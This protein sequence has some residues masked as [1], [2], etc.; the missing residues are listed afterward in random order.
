MKV[1]QEDNT[2]LARIA[3]THDNNPNYR[4]EVGRIMGIREVVV[5]DNYSGRF[6]PTTLAARGLV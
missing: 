4:H 3:K 1:L 5:N 6:A 2:L